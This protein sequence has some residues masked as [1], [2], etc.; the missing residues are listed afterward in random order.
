MP[1]TPAQW[2]LWWCCGVYAFGRWI[3]DNDPMTRSI[4]GR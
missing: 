1:M 3:H 4:R 2:C